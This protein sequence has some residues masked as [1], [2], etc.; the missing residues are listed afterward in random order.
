[1]R[2]YQFCQKYGIVDCQEFVFYSYLEFRVSLFIF[3]YEIRVLVQMDGLVLTAEFP[4]VKKSSDN[5]KEL[6]QFERFLDKNQIHL[7]PVTGYL[8]LSYNLAPERYI[9]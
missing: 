1:M 7:D 5:D 3:D 4:F 9:N 6:E 2:A 8:N